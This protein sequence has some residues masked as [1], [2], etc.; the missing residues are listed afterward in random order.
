MTISSGAAPSRF[1]MISARQTKDKQA[2]AIFETKT[3]RVS[4]KNRCLK[5]KQTVYCK[6][7]CD[8]HPYG[9][10]MLR[11]SIEFGKNRQKSTGSSIKAWERIDATQSGEW[12]DSSID[13]TKVL[14]EKKKR[15]VSFI[16]ISYSTPDCYKNVKK[17]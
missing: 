1:L 2:L 4:K 5:F 8:M 6:Q 16:Y 12:L 15:M 11:V 14:R 17:V 7:N 13:I 9:V 10:M 3:F